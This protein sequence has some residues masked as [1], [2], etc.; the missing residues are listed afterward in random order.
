MTENKTKRQTRWVEQKEN[1]S[2]FNIA[3]IEFTFFLQIELLHLGPL[4]VELVSEMFV[5]RVAERQLLLEAG[6]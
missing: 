3:T 6:R 4:R 2:N 1:T 5:L